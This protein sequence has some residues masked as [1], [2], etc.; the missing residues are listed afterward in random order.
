MDWKYTTIKV[1]VYLGLI[2]LWTAFIMLF[3][4]LGAQVGVQVGRMI[5]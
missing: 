3:A 2:T 4:Y 1:S 5:G